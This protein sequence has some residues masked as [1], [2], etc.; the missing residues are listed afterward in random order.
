M[1]IFVY[2][3]L[4]PKVKA[5]QWLYAWGIIQGGF[6]CWG[7]GSNLFLAPQ[8]LLSASRQPQEGCKESKQEENSWGYQSS[9]P[10]WTKLQAKVDHAAIAV[11]KTQRRCD[12]RSYEAMLKD[13]TEFAAA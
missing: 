6:D 9:K 4:N 2:N 1:I 13:S 3:E 7:N 5:A 8:R 11:E 12:H 10:E